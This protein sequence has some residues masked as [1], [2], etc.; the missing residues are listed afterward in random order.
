MNGKLDGKLISDC[1]MEARSLLGFPMSKVGRKYPTIFE[2][3]SFISSFAGDIQ[4]IGLRENLQ[5]SIGVFTI[6]YRAFL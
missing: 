3:T 5:E 6:K 4:W 1:R 2:A